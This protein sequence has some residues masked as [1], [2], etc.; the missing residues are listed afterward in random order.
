MINEW[1]KHLID[2]LKECYTEEDLRECCKDLKFI[3]G[4]NFDT[5]IMGFKFTPVRIVNRKI[6]ITGLYDLAFRILWFF[7]TNKM[8]G[9]SI[10]NSGEK[11]FI[12]PLYVVLNELSRVYGNELTM[13]QDIEE[14]HI[15]KILVVFLKKGNKFSTIKQKMQ[16]FKI[17]L[18]HNEQLPMILRLHPRIAH[19]FTSDYIENL[20]RE[21][22]NLRKDEILEFNNN[23]DGTN[24][25]RTNLIYEGFITNK[26]QVPLYDMQKLIS[27]AFEYI[28]HSEEI[29]EIARILR[30]CCDINEQYI[31]DKIL[32]DEFIKLSTKIGEFKEPTLC[33]WQNKINLHKS[34][35]LYNANG[36]H[37]G[38]A[39]K[40]GMRNNFL[41]ILDLLEISCISVILLGTGMRITE[42]ILL[43]RNLEFK[44]SEHYMLKKVS[45]KTA[46]TEKG[47][48]LTRPIP[49]RLKEPLECLVEIA[50]IK[51]SERGKYLILG[52]M[53]YDTRS[54]TLSLSRATNMLSL[55]AKEADIKPNIRTHHFRHTIAY[56]VTSF[57]E[58]GLELASMLL[59]HKSTKMTLNYLSMINIDIAKARLELDKQRANKLID[60]IVEKVGKN[61]KVF[62]ENSKFLTPDASFVGKMADEFKMSLKKN[63]RELVNEEKFSIIQSTHCMCIHEL[64]Q[65]QNLKCQVGYDLETMIVKG[66]NISRCQGINC[67]N[68][69]FFEE[70]V[71]KLKELYGHIADNDIRNR[72]E[73]NTIFIEMG[74]FENTPYDKLFKEYDKYSKEK[75]I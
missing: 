61:E 73:K 29:L 26:E 41:R 35:Y 25:T 50:N 14:K 8:F 49:M 30:K 23:D 21:Y 17:W 33:N 56:L 45:Y 9:L 64:S 39:T 13:F 72:L 47:E 65:P 10:Q 19:C 22:K 27:K 59:G 28:K 24:V 74:G 46:S 37:I 58:E 55:L 15:K 16:I 20:M 36:K 11:A 68:S 52:A 34:Y 3:N 69:I 66:T 53:S 7:K 2:Q 60:K 75:V 31:K 63:L 6:E 18:R 48:E 4:E 32:F 40:G 57:D 5:R 71:K 43:D 70:D 62:G 54:N 38:T 67:G 42:L 1:R 44:E 12:D 51:D